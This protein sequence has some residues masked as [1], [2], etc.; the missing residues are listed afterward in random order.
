MTPDLGLM[1]VGSSPAGR[2]FAPGHEEKLMTEQVT[3][4]KSEQRYELAIDGEVAIAAYET[5]GETIVFTHTEVP[6]ALEGHGIGSRLIKGAL[7]DVRAQ[8]QHIV[9]DC[10]FVAAYLDRH[11]DEQD[12]VG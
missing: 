11:P 6:S 3:N 8:G 1:P 9:A 10:S 12:L 5:R 4:N 2:T 7:A